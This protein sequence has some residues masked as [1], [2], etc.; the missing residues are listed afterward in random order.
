MFNK[1]A[2]CFARHAAALVVVHETSK[3]RLEDFQHNQTLMLTS[4][5]IIAF[6]RIITD[7]LKSK[8]NDS[9]TQI[10]QERKQKFAEQCILTKVKEKEGISP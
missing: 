7:I 8:K 10:D 3:E 2:L 4:Y 6:N 9:Q 1:R 5:Q